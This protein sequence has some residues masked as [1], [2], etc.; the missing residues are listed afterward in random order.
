MEQEAEAG[1]RPDM[2][3]DPK[4]LAICVNWNGRAVLSETLDSLLGCAHPSLAILVVDNASTDGS[5]DQIPNEI[6]ALRLDRNLGY[7]GAINAGLREGLLRHR[8]VDCV[9]ALNNDVTVDAN[10]LGRLLECA[11]KRGPGI[12]GPQIRRADQPDRLDAAWGEVVWHHV[13]VRLLGKG[14]PADDPRFHRPQ[15]VDVL[16]GCALL[17]SSEVIEKVGRFDERFFMYHEEVD[18][19]LRARKAGFPVMYC[20]AAR[21]LHRG[22]HSTRNAPLKR[23]YWV[24]RSTVQFFRK[25]RPG[26]LKWLKFWLTMALSTAFNI[27]TLRW[28]RLVAILRGVG[29]GFSDWSDGSDSSDR[30]DRSDRSDPSDRSDWSDRSDSSDRSDGSDSK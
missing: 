1:S 6:E 2:S 22:A 21:C 29:S 18:Y 23:V 14:A 24:R 8:N 27:V 7:A 5:V 17:I 4:V 13:L 25:H 10:M 12:F 19:Q 15:A 3:I 9:L 30:S 28:R 16:L 26:L 11:K 20:P